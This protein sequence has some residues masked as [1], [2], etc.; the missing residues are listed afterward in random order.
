MAGSSVT[1]EHQI[2]C[3]ASVAQL[4]QLTIRNLKYNA[5]Q[6]YEKVLLNC[7]LLGEKTR[8]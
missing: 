1:Y 7:E 6:V 3:L 4:F 8:V 5:S 2:E